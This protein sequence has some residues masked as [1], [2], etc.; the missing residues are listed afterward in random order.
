MAG[1]ILD[2]M[3]FG[4]GGGWKDLETMIAKTGAGAVFQ[5]PICQ[6]VVKKMLLGQLFKLQQNQG[7]NRRKDEE[8]QENFRFYLKKGNW[9]M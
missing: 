7:G 8:K 9:K 2:R 6:K 4:D 1:E 5:L 3:E